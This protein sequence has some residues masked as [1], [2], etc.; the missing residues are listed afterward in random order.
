MDGFLPIFFLLVVLKIPV[1]GALWLVW[2]AGKAPETEAE[3][4]DSGGGFER[5]RPLPIRPRGPHHLPGGAGAVGRGRGAPPGQRRPVFRPNLDPRTASTSAGE[6]PSKPE[7]H[8]VPSPA[9]P[10]TRRDTPTPPHRI[11]RPA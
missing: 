4:E 9:T 7:G 2:W 3:P 5:R 6:K 1:L 11:R 10:A 8:P